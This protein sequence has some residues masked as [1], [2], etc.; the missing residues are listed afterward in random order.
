VA[1]PRLAPGNPRV[2][3]Y[4]C[5]DAVRFMS[6]ATLATDEC[7]SQKEAAVTRLATE[8]VESSQEPRRRRLAVAWSAQAITLYCYIAGAFFV[9]YR[10]WMRPAGVTT[11]L[12]TSLLVSLVTLLRFSCISGSLRSIRRR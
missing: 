5:R 8:V 12:S 10:M 11:R 3:R 2:S 4:F 7:E 9:T 1:L 6:V